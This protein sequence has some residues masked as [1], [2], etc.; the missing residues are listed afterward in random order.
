F[1]LMPWAAYCGLAAMAIAGLAILFG[2]RL[3]A[4]RQIAIGIL[5]FLIGAAIAYVPWEYSEMRGMVPNDITTDLQNP[6]PY[7]AVLALRRLH[8][9]YRG[10]RRRG[11]R[12][13]PHRCPL[14]LAYRHRRFWHQ[15]RAGAPLYRRAARAHLGLSSRRTP[16]PTRQLQR[17]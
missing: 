2:R 8:R 3:I 6:P 17:C 13:E 15:C 11:R 1:S 16:G 4:G 7:V 5:A 9:R 10:P 14:F 12:G